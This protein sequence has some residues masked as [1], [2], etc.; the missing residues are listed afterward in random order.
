[1]T[2]KRAAPSAAGQKTVQESLE[3][4]GAELPATPSFARLALEG[5]QALMRTLPEAAGLFDGRLPLMTAFVMAISAACAA[6]D[7]ADPEWLA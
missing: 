5:Q 3:T 7:E 1:M 4:G 6:R 2:T